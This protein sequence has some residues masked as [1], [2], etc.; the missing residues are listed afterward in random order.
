MTRVRLKEDWVFCSA[1]R[2][3]GKDQECQRPPSPWFVMVSRESGCSYGEKRKQVV[4]VK[5]KGN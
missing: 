4:R 5:L 3:A 2:H 1:C